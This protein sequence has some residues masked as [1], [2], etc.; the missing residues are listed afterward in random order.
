MGD[1][2]RAAIFCFKLFSAG[3][4]IIVGAGG[5]NG[6]E[7]APIG[8]GDDARPRFGDNA[9]NFLFA[10]TDF[11]PET[12]LREMRVGLWL[13]DGVDLSSTAFLCGAAVCRNFTGI[14]GA[15]IS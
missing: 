12:E 3:V 8:I 15:D 11:K 1:R 14:I 10:V 6:S 5:L 9:R 7:S 2:L 13:D 4:S